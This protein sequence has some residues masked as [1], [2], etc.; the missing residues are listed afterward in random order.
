ML[1]T[2]KTLLRA[3]A[4]P[5]VL[6]L[7]AE[8]ILQL[9][10][11]VVAATGRDLPVGWATDNTRVLAIGDSNTFGIYLQE[12]ES[13]PAQL[14]ALWNKKHPD[15]PIEV[16]NL[17]YPGTNSFR[18]ADTIAEVLH[19]FQ[20]D[21]VLLTIGIN[22]IFTASE[23]VEGNLQAGQGDSSLD[24]IDLIRRYSRLYKLVYMARQGQKA[25]EAATDT[26]SGN[27]TAAGAKV[28]KREVLQWSDDS[29]KRMRDIKAFKKANSQGPEDAAVAAETITHGGKTIVMVSAYENSADPDREKGFH[30]IQANLAAIDRQVKRSGATLY[31]MSYAASTG[32]YGRTN[33]EITGYASGNAGVNLIDVAAD[34][35]KTCPKSSQCPDLFFK[36][37]HPRA[38][39]Y[40][41]VASSV[42]A[43]L[44][45]DQIVKQRTD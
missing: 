32:F 45:R 20:P 14:Q 35:R 39:A 24:P 44:E 2:R 5:I 29:E 16:A 36:D 1:I 27:T 6:V 43:R 41:I 13:Y 4:L 40:S 31:V 26:G 19:N 33:R 8:L 34:V 28:N 7:A 37:L 25:G 38:P 30:H 9:G 12:E 3:L 15:R 21:I 10:A 22:D 18:V 23:Y 42:A 11:L 17:G